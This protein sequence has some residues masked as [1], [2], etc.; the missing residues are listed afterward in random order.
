MAYRRAWDVVKGVPGKVNWEQ[1]DVLD[2]IGLGQSLNDDCF[3][4]LPVK[5]R[6]FYINT[7]KLITM[8]AFVVFNLQECSWGPLWKLEVKTIM[9]TSYARGPKELVYA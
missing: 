5:S 7:K 6:D 8:M 1:L 2:Y 9:D 4:L 3:S